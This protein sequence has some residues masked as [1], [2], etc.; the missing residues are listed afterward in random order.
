MLEMLDD[1]KNNK[2]K[3]VKGELD[4]VLTF[5]KILGGLL[6]KRG[7]VK[8]EPLKLKFAD[9]LNPKSNSK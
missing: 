8:M 3:I 6:R 5:R 4:L 1:L 9:A 7:A 2:K